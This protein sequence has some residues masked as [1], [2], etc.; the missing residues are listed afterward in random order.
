MANQ[1][2]YN[3]EKIDNPYNNALEREGNANSVF[4][5]N[6]DSESGSPAVDS[7]SDIG[8]NAVSGQSFGDMWISNFIK[9]NNYLPKKRGFFIDGKTGNV[10]FSN[11]DLSGGTIKYGKT[12]FSDSTNAG[13][14]ISSA[15]V[16]IGSAGDVSKL[17]YT[18]ISGTFDFVGTI[19]SKATSEIVA[20]FGTGDDASNIITD[21]INERL[22]TDSK[23][24]LSDFTFSSSDY[25]GALKTGTITWNTSTGAIT[26]G[27]GIVINKNGIVG[28]L[29]GATKFSITTDG[30][31]TFSGDVAGATIT[32]GTI[33]IGSSNNIFKADSN[34]IYLGNASFASAPFRVS[35]TGA[36]TVSDISVT[37]GSISI[38]TDAWN[39]DSDGNMWWGN[40]V[41]FASANDGVSSGGVNKRVRVTS[42]IAQAG[43]FYSNTADVQNVALD[44]DMGDGGGATTNSLPALRVAY[45]GIGAVIDVDINYTGKGIYVYRQ[46]GS[47]VA[48]L[49]DFLSTNNAS[50]CTII[51]SIKTGSGTVIGIDMDHTTS[52]NVSNIGVQMGLSSGNSALCYAFRFNGSEIV[53]AAV[54]GSQSKKIRISIA[55]TDFFIPCYTA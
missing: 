49:L 51:N 25:A 40:A 18:V 48:P 35:M 2:D 52:S 36:M 14:V 28:A 12:G 7:P 38:G 4:S 50:S 15:G 19:S 42:S 34:G 3:Y 21:V 22:D 54:G 27:T 29:A 10:E 31:A 6:G 53:S 17:K 43:Y 47:G 32:G 16:Y 9:S 41:S 11:I 1:V 13:Y 8:S 55:G 24:I 45:G 46:L 20:A 30:N 44:I 33:A 26:G 39:V 23:Q 37:G 5:G